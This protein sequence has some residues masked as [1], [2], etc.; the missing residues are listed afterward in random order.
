MSIAARLKEQEALIEMLDAA[1]LAAGVKRRPTPEWL[2]CLTPQE[3]ALMGALYGSYPNIIPRLDLLEIIP[4]PRGNELD[5]DP[6]LIN[7]LI[8]KCRSKLGCRDAV[9]AERGIGVRMGKEFYEA[10]P[11]KELD[12]APIAA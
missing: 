5:R 8:S 1:L 7:V 2:V 6:I 12:A 9:V 10:L 3:R 11:K 4:S